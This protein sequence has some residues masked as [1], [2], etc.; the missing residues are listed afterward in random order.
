MVLPYADRG[1]S[2]LWQAQTDMY[3]RMAGGYMNPPPPE[4]W[5]WPILHSLYS[6]NRPSDFDERLRMFLEAHGVKAIVVAGQD[7]RYWRAILSGLRV[8]PIEVDDVSVYRVP[9]ALAESNAQEFAGGNDMLRLERRS[10]FA[11]YAALIVA[12]DRYM[13]DGLPM[14]KLTPAEAER[15]NLLSVK[16]SGPPV[17]EGPGAASNWQDGMWLGA[18]RGNRIGVGIVGCR[19]VLEPVIDDFAPYASARYFPYFPLLY[20]LLRHTTQDFGQLLM[21]FSPKSIHD[22]AH[23]AQGVVPSRPD[24]RSGRQVH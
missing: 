8:V 17:M 14:S 13:T 19:A 16:Q 10:E 6:G 21:V 18:W 2:L 20:R 1:N 24:G 7:R 3:F 5:C 11:R 15:L 4:S 22:A 12:A 23:L 9:S